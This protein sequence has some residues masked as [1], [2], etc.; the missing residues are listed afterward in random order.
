MKKEL[1]LRLSLMGRVKLYVAD[2]ADAYAN[3][4]SLFLGE[5]VST[6]HVMRITHAV[7]AFT[8]LVFSYGNALVSLLFLVWFVL[9]L[10]DCK[11]A[12]IK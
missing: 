6:G 4:F 8:V 2:W 1:S 10:L 11:R 3:L 7:L 12:G 5:K 9:T